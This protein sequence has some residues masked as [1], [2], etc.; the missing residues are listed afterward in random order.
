MVNCGPLTSPIRAVL[1]A[2]LAVP[3]ERFVPPALAGIAYLDTEMFV[4]GHG[5][6]RLLKP[7]VFGKMLQAAEI[8]PTDHVLDV[9]CATGYSAAVLGKLC[10]QVV[11]LEEDPDLARQARQNLARCWRCQR[12]GGRGAVADGW[13]AAAPY[14]VIVVN[15]L[16]E[17]VPPA[18]FDQ[19]T[20]SGRL[21]AIVGDGPAP[22][23]TVYRCVEGQCQRLGRFLTP[24]GRLC[25][26]LH[27]RRRFSSDE[28]GLAVLSPMR[29]DRCG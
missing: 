5:Q 14:D 17:T 22:K 20:E 4:G 11:A 23:A 21:V 25:P 7:M 13:P 15:G 8:T 19:L 1:A 26:D 10:A 28:L 6:R 29:F 3:R 12:F 24:P 9:G 16:C 2:M 27:G 18:L